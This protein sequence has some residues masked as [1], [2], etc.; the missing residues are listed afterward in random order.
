[1]AKVFKAIGN[2]VTS[3]VKA[4]VN[5]VSS[6]VKAVVNVVA[7]VVNFVAQPFLGMLGGMPDIPSAAAEADRQQG[8]LIQQTGSNIDIPVVYGFRKVGGTVVFAE[9]GSTNN[10]Y[11]YVVYVF[12][13]GVV[14]GLRKV[15]IDD[16]ELPT[17]LT[18]NVNAG[19][20]VDVNADR[21][22]GRVRMMWNPGVYYANPASSTVGSYWKTNIFADSPSFTSSM[23][24]NGLATLAVRYEWKE[25]KT[26]ADADNNPFKG[27]IPEVQVELLGRRIAALDSQASGYEYSQAPVRYSTNPAEILLDYL[28]NPRYGK[29]LVNNDIHWD[30]WI[31]AANKCNTT[32]NYVTGQSYAGPI[33]TSNFVLST[34]QT[35]FANTKTLLMGFRGYMPYVQGKYKLKIEDAG[36]DTDILSGVATVVMTATSKPYPKNQYTGNV[37]DIVGSITY[38]GIEK[39]NKYSAVVVTYVDPDQKWSNQQ[40][41]WPETEEER[42]SYIVKD[43]GRENKMEATFPTI[44]NYA[45]AKDMAK[46][47]FLKSRRQE[48]ISLTVSSEGLELEPGD[49]IRVQGNILDFTTSSSLIIP[50]R[51]VSVKI[52]DNMTVTLGL[53]KNPDDIYPHARYNEED[54]VAAIYV[55]KGSDIYYPSSVNRGDPIGLVPPT[56]APFPVIPPTLPPSVPNP[57]PTTPPIDPN[58]PVVPSPPAPVTPTPPAPVVPFSAVLSLKSSSAAILQG[59]TVSYNLIFTQPNDG[60]Y[61]YSIMYW[62]ANAYSAW[63]Q[64]RMDTLPGSGGDI[65]VSFISTYG[66]FTYY[67]RSFASDGRGSNKVLY[68]TVSLNSGSTVLTGVA[69]PP[70]VVQITDGWAPDA[71]LVVT[72][73]KYD[74]TIDQFQLLP[75]QIAGRRRVSVKMTQITYATSAITNTLI[76][77]VRIYYKLSTD[78][79][80]S[81]EDYN[82]DNVAGYTPFTQLTWDL[83]GDFGAVGSGNSRYSFV[84]RLTYRNGTPA[85][86][87]YYASSPSVEFG[88]AGQTTGFNIFAYSAVGTIDPGVSASNEYTGMVTIPSTFVLQTTDQAPGGTVATGAEIIPSITSIKQPDNISNTLRFIFNKSTSTKFSGFKIRMR[89]VIPGANPTTVVFEVGSIVDAAT[90]TIIYNINNGGFVLNTSYDWVITAQYF[91]P[92]TG[93]TKEA[94]NSLVCLKATVPTQSNYIYNDLMN[95]IFN[96]TQQDTLTAIGSLSAPFASIPTIGLSGTGA[97]WIKRQVKAYNV[98]DSFASG[99][100]QVVGESAAQPEVY[101]VKTAGVVSSWALNTYYKLAFTTPNDT[102]DS[103]IVYR[104]V[105]DQNGHNDNVTARGTVPKYYGLGAWE[106]V[107]VPRTSMT[108]TSGY[109]LLNLRGPFS[110]SLFPNTGTPANGAFQTFYGPSGKWPYTWSGSNYV[111]DVYPYYGAGNTAWTGTTTQTKYAEFLFV[112]KDSGVEGTKAARLT[113]FNTASSGIGYI[114]DANG[115]NLGVSR[116]SIVN[117]SDY[118]PYTAGYKRNINEAITSSSGGN[119]A[120]AAMIVPGGSFSGGNLYAS[121]GPPYKVSSAD[122]PGAWKYLGGPENGDGVY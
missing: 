14:E 7:D 31:K 111:N 118:N 27:N 79:Y 105:F 35:I 82:F 97:T 87:Q 55:P 58:N 23:N 18:A 43:G 45:I 115:F 112:I 32:V 74:D 103:I 89:Q 98:S 52:N 96:W 113:D 12:S 33:L 109:Y 5:V 106:K 56:Q 10:K 2:A 116:L 76:Q 9:T 51:V 11:L 67:I 42:Q 104:R 22:N 90:Q 92:T 37:C 1:M 41:V 77:G 25:I 65:P 39:S 121:N 44:T 24:F 70:T 34:G 21:Y 54:L 117:V 119:I 30:S 47:L 16:W 28:R 114:Q 102:F 80:Y 8:V 94:T 59:S 20:I 81:Y 101:A 50:W 46:L 100:T 83:S 88:N 122:G 26:Q 95:S 60:L 84:I 6:V 3:V 62:R 19:Q 38:T 68:G 40:V 69:Q 75:K 57:P 4:V 120:N 91:D 63:T 48:T 86:K 78:T 61:Q 71:T 85:Q 72:T 15:F 53:V 107:V 108:K 13:E 93:T 64:V 110:P 66:V 73:P 99:G 29:G 17:N 49:N 36:N